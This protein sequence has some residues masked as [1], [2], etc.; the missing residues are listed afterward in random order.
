MALDCL[1]LLDRGLSPL[2][3]LLG[4]EQCQKFGSCTR[5]SGMCGRTEC[6]CALL[7]ESETRPV[8]S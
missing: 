6:K 7:A 2:V 3:T 1:P 5:T 8:R 4:S